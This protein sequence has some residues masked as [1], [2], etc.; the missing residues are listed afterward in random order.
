[1]WQA[2]VEALFLLLAGGLWAQSA[3]G[4]E[5]AEKVAQSPLS[6]DWVA[7]SGCPRQAEVEAAVLRQARVGPRPGSP[8]KARGAI[9]E[10]DGHWRLV[11]STEFEGMRGERRLTASS[12]RALTEAATLTLALILNPESQREAPARATSATPSPIPASAAP[13]SP[14]L[15]PIWSLAA[16]AGLQAGLLKHVGPELSLGFGLSLGSASPSLWL[17]ANYRP[18]Q[19]ARVNDTTGAGGRVWAAS[20][21]LLGCWDFGAR[22][23]FGPCA[24]FELTRTEGRGVVVSN[25]RAGVIYFASGVLGVRAGLGITQALS[26][27]IEGFGLAQLHRPQLYLEEIGSVLRPSP[28]GGKLRVGVE[29]ELP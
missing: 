9:E 18:P 1:M 17:L 4:Q 20:G 28:F 11:L 23:R 10:A 8:V 25:P 6:L 12:C 26:I 15:T 2:A 27:K 22:I 16:H 24:G 19:D 14:P 29:L 3:Q 21:G 13:R 7:P 5:S